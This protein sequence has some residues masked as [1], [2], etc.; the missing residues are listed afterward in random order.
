M[1]IFWVIGEVHTVF[2]GEILQPI[3]VIQVI[4]SGIISMDR[5]GDILGQRRGTY[6]IWWGNS[7]HS[8]FY[9]CDK[10]RNNI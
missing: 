1:G 4:K 9:S 7:L 10:V 8:I 3:H 6:R 5:H 2:G